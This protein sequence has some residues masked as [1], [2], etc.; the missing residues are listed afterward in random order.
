MGVIPDDFEIKSSNDTWFK[1]KPGKNK[2]RILDDAE[3]GYE[4]WEETDGVKKP[5]RVPLNTPV[6]VEAADE[7]GK[8]LA[9]PIWNYETKRIQIWVCSKVSI[10][11]EIKA[12]DKDSDWGDCTQYDMDIER[13]GEDKNNT[14]YR[15]TPKPKST[16]DP[17]I[18]KAYESNLP[19]MKLLFKGGD[20]LS[21]SR[22]DTFSDEDLKK[23]DEAFGN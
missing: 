4:W 6:P 1:I 2:I 15:V 16:L 18:Q 22:E 14:R 8:F 21:S 20:P 7:V 11:K 17:E 12:L 13:V 10:Q 3:V 9:F 5:V 23:I 19:D